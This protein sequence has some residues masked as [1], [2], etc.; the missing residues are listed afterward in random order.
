MVEHA[1]ITAETRI[2]IALLAERRTRD[3]KVAVSLFGRSGG[4]T[5]FCRVNFLCWLLVAVRSI[6]VL[7]QWHVKDLG[8]FD[9][10]L[11]GR[12]QINTAYT[13]LTHQ[14]RS[15]LIMLGRQSVGKYQGNEL[16]R[17]SPGNARP[18]V[19]ARSATVDRSC[20]N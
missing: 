3:R 11:G 19:S 7:P 1:A 10:R 4:K 9:E 2:G 8:H 20:P 6:P 12:L 14:S 18:V 13:P 16:R 5:F 17:Y 15:G